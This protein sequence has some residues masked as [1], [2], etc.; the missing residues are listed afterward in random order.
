MGLLVNGRWQTGNISSENTQKGAYKRSESSFRDRI[1][2]EKG[3]KFPPEAGR[4][5]LYISLACPWAHRTYIF[6]KLKKLE[7]IVSLS[8]VDPYMGEK[9]WT[10]S[11]NPGCIGDFVNGKQ[12]LYEVYVKAKKDFSGRVTVP[13]LWDIKKNTIV[14]NES[15]DII[16]MFNS[17]FNQ[18]SGDEIDYYPEEIRADIDQ[19]NDFV[20]TNINN[21]VYKCGFAETQGAYAEAYKSLFSALDII[22]E[23]LVYNRFLNGEQITEADWR[24]FTTLIRFDAVYYIHFKCNHR[25]IIDYAN[26]SRYLNEL[27]FYEDVAKTVNFAHIKEHY[28][29]SHK[30]INPKGIIPLGPEIRLIH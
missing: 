7:D 1:S 8:I 20:Y 21:G 6:L 13:V 24:L 11:E 27:Y 2:A 9:G 26:L 23:R 25:R 19:I 17:E 29:R 16:R 5:H 30:E 15:A 18:L 14:N 12:Y 22:E 3:A 28:Y 4:Y 10:F